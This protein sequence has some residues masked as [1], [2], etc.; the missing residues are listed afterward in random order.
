MVAIRFCLTQ[1]NSHQ[2]KS[3][4]IKINT[5]I[6]QTRVPAMLFNKLN[7]RSHVLNP[8][9]SRQW[10]NYHLGLTAFIKAQ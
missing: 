6:G 8:A 5:T 9:N 1:L 4:F 7:Q 10:N 3:L 2:S